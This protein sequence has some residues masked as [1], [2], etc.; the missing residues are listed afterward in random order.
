MSRFSIREALSYGWQTYKTDWLFFV[1]L[2][3][4]VAFINWLAPLIIRFLPSDWLIMAIPINIASLTANMMIGMGV[5]KIY[6]DKVDNKPTGYSE[7]FSYSGYFFRYFG[8]KIN[9]ILI[10]I[11]GAILLLIPGVIFSVKLKFWPWTMVDQD[12]GMIESLFSSWQM[13]AG[14]KLDLLIFGI[15][16]GILNILGFLA[17]GIGLL[18]TVPVTTLSMAYVYRKLNYTPKEVI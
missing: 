13:T 12:K 17:V 11:F 5:M 6:I 14:I 2:V 1:G 4:L 15:V 18:I 3:I 7:L 8:A 9:S 10:I 16:L